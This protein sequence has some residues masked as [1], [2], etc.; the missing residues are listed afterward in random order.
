MCG[1]DASRVSLWAFV[2]FWGGSFCEVTLSTAGNV[3]VATV[4]SEAWVEVN[5][6]WSWVQHETFLKGTKP[7]SQAHKDPGMKILLSQW[8][9]PMLWVCMY[10][11]GFA[12]GLLVFFQVR[13]SPPT[14]S[15]EFLSPSFGM[16]VRSSCLSHYRTFEDAC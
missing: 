2:F 3:P 4:T 14:G 13:M 15:S 12:L 9:F 16:K 8:F 11:F 7:T 6:F 5:V 10:S 1:S